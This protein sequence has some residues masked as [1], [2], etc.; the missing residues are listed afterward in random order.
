MNLSPAELLRLPSVDRPRPPRRSLLTFEASVR[1]LL[2]SLSLILAGLYVL[3]IS[4]QVAYIAVP[5]LIGLNQQQAQEVLSAAGLRSELAL[6]KYSAFERGQ[7]LAQSPRPGQHANAGEA[8]LMTISAGTQGFEIP[9]LIGLDLTQARV[10]LEQLG[11]S[12]S[13]VLLQSD[14]PPGVVMLTLPP[15]RTQVL[16]TEGPDYADEDL[17]VTLYVATHISS[18]GLQEFQL[19]GLSVAIEPRF[20]ATAE[21]D[22]SFDVARR[23]SSLF[24]ASNAEVTM[25]RTSSER[26]VAPDEYLARAARVSPQLYI[27]LSITDAVSASADSDNAPHNRD[28]QLSGIIVRSSSDSATDPGR[29]IYQRMVQSQLNVRFELVDSIGVAQ[30]ARN[31]IQIV[32]GNAASLDDMSNFSESFWRDH[33]ARAIYMASS[34]QF[35]LSP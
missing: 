18:A 35:D 14:E 9:D 31:D 26:F 30:E 29:L 6:E 13:V 24:E 32:L 19:N 7:V 12:A 21:G 1:A 22:V 15:A 33:V 16:P 4:G 3:M 25:L 28:T 11:L 10:L 20:T 34:P 5:N 8:V 27:T 23:L 2:W 17:A